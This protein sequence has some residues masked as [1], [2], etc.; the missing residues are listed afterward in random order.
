MAYMQRDDDRLIFLPLGGSGEIGMNLNLYGHKGKWLMVDCGMAFADEALPGVDLIFPDPD[1]IED[2]RDALAGLVVTHGHEDHI[3]AIP[4]LWQRF[5]CPIYATPFTAELIQ[6]KLNEAG[7]DDVP[8]VIVD[9]HDAF[10]VGPFN[11]RYLAL[12]HS[13]AEGHGIVIKTAKGT[14]FHTGDWKLDDNPLIGPVC[15]S[16]ALE[17]LGEDGVLALVGDSTNVFNE[18]ESGSEADVRASLKELVA[19]IE[20]RVVITT[21]ASNVARLET[22]GEVAK[23]SGRE[24]VLLGRSM[25]RIYKA[26]KATGY[27]K[28]FP[29]L[30]SEEDAEYLPKDKLLI[31]CTGCQGESRA[32]LSRIARGDH[33]N[34][35]LVSGD[36]VIFSSKMIPG[37]E[38]VLGSLYNALSVRDINIVTEKDAFV[39]VSGHPGRAELR[40]M[41]DWVKPKM[42]IPVHG[43]ARHLKRHAEFGR[44]LG[45]EHTIVPS[46]GDII[47]IKEN[48][49]KLIDHAPY[50]RL[51][52]DGKSVLSVDDPA[53]VDRKRLMVNGLVIVSLV[54]ADDNALAAEPLIVIK[55]ISGCDDDAFY[56]AI[57]D[58]AETAI[59]NIGAR[60][61]ESDSMVEEAVRIAIRRYTRR[62]IGKNPGVEVMITRSDELEL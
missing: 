38:L 56:D 6:D 26:A 39:H 43:E 12:A 51:A 54:F 19:D 40:K 60:A 16:T 30:V 23:A 1:F 11:I 25:H 62:E 33:R 57:L 18:S 27:L 42:L 61:R 55:G 15:P 41:Y 49:L 8:M 7:L 35:S 59:E 10:N 53:L 9:H 20:G 34:I 47:E 22:I 44:T 14:I 36:T 58:T 21:F 5:Q 3:G 17:A 50:G 24:I 52:L 31:A 4:H 46:N 28:K 2:E 32:A 13:T 45:I 48:G 29:K 37:N